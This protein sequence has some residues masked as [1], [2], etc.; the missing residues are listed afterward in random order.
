MGT[1]EK[2]LKKLRRILKSAGSV[3]VA[4]SGGVDSTFLLAIAADVL[5]DKVLAVT[6]VSAA[7]PVSE[8][9]R[10]VLLA[11]YLGV[12]HRLVADSPQKKFWS[13]PKERCY[14]CKK[15]LFIQ[16]NRLAGK[17]GLASVVEA[18]NA[19][20]VK[21]Y[22]PGTMA[23]KELRVRS[24]LKE[25]GL[26]KNEIRAL[27]KAKGLATWK[28]PA[29]A[30]LASRIPYGEKITARR[31][32]K[33]GRAEEFLR[34]RKFSQVRVRLHGEAARIEVAEEKI[35]LVIKMRKKISAQLKSL[36]F[37]YVALDLDGYRSGSMNEVL[38]WTRK[39]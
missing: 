12:R 33:I 7:M 21:D 9:K 28:Q 23:V 39:R 2:K 8:K 31:L 4:F 24:P 27:S 30:C 25:A 38:G 17:L 11:K 13:N 19:D 37:T 14:Y 36:G 3:L 29:M 1:A 5:K 18:S 35:P 22:R 32:L 16:L 15:G 6:A 10:A 26:T 34:T 20:D